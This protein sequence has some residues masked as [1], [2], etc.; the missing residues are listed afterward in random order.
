MRPPTLRSPHVRRDAYPIGLLSVA[1]VVAACAG[2]A[3]SVPPSS[4]AATESPSPIATPT[5]IPTLEAST[6]EAVEAPPGAISVT[7][8]PGPDYVPADITAPA[9]T[10]VFFLDARQADV[11]HNVVIAINAGDLPLAKSA[12]LDAGTAAVFTV[13]DLEPGTYEFWCTF[14]GHFEAGMKGTLTIT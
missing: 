10:V 11:L 12:N 1:L 6:E 9:G 3:T 13:H 7:V 2:P 14:P 5:A 4:A 8:G